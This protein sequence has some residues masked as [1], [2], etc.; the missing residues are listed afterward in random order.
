MSV[1]VGPF[2][3]ADLG[4]RALVDQLADRAV[5]RN[6]RCPTIAFALHVGGLNCRRDPA[7]VR[8]MGHADVVY[9]DGASAVLVA[10]CAGAHGIERAPTTDLGWD[11]LAAL[12]ARL[13]R[14]PRLALLGGPAGLAERAG[15]VIACSG[16]ATPV[17]AESGYQTYWPPVLNRIAA[18]RPDVLAVGIGAPAEMV[19]VDVHAAELP[20]CL[21]L[22]CGGWFGYVT[23]SEKRAPTLLRRTGLEWIAR[24]A[25]APQRLGPRYVRGVLSTAELCAEALLQRPKG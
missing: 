7:F 23:G 3:V 24:V 5:A 16:A 4:R 18:A 17:L 6:G 12:G 14:P 15:A 22:T 13:G 2:R 25:Q 9:A 8:A 19:W 10:R 1:A 21:V 20:A 11:L